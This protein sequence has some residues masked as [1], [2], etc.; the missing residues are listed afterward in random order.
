MAST[1]PLV[2]GF[3]ESSCKNRPGLFMR[4]FPLPRGIQSLGGLF[5]ARKHDDTPSGGTY[6]EYS[7]H[8]AWCH[9]LHAIIIRQVNLPADKD[10]PNVVPHGEEW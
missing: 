5:V 9:K 8:G 3:P 10:T 1:S 4:L 2:P 7:T 6:R